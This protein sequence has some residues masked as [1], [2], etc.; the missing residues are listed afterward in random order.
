MDF[1]HEINP[2]SNFSFQN[3]FLEASD[4]TKEENVIF[5]EKIKIFPTFD[6][7]SNQEGKSFVKNCLRRIM[8]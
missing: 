4:D 5:F 7:S 8:K 1:Q 3:T 2:P 6:N